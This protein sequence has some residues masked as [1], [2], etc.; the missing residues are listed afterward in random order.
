MPQK[1][2]IALSGPASGGKCCFIFAHPI[3]LSQKFI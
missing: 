3:E 2:D 1:H